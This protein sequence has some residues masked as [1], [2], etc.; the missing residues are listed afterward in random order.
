MAISISYT[1][2]NIV[3]RPTKFPSYGDFSQTFVMPDYGPWWSN[4]PSGAI[5]RTPYKCPKPSNPGGL[6]ALWAGHCQN[7]WKLLWDSSLFLP[8]Q[9]QGQV[10]NR[11][12]KKILTLLYDQTFK[13]FAVSKFLTSLG[14]QIP[15]ILNTLKS[16]LTH[17]LPNKLWT[18]LIYSCPLVFQNFPSDQ[19]QTW[20]VLS[21]P[22]QAK[23]S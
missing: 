16:G 12:F 14:Y 7:A 21:Q 19:D 15:Y 17:A 5:W 1:A 9:G 13:W 8:I 23:P 4:S 2:H 22:S 3:G 18:I 10:T 11:I 20:K 6:V